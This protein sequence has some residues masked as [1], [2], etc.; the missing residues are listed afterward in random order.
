MAANGPHAEGKGPGLVIRHLLVPMGCLVAS[1]SQ[2]DLASVLLPQLLQLV[3]D[4][5]EPVLQIFKE[6]SRSRPRQRAAARATTPDGP[7]DH[8]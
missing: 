5:G 2:A 3:A 1:S 7:A 4:P 8:W 6:S